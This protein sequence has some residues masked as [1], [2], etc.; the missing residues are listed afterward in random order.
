[1]KR[2][3]LCSDQISV[4]EIETFKSKLENNE[5]DDVQ[6]YRELV[7]LE[8]LISKKFDPAIIFKQLLKDKYDEI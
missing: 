1:M 3:F 8:H 2:Y 6:N 5:I 7:I 4:E